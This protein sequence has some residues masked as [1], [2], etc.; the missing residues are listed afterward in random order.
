MKQRV[1]RWVIAVFMMFTGA[2]AFAQATGTFNGRVVDQADAVLP[3]A[4]VTA[5]NTR[6][7]VARTDGHERRRIVQLAGVGARPVQRERGSERVRDIDP[8]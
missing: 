3:G 1:V 7:G 5:T 4:T 2:S 8:A 6:T